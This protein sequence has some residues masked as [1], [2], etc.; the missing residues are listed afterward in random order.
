MQVNILTEVQAKLRELYG[1]G[2]YYT[3]TYSRPEHELSYCGK[4]PS[5]MEEH[6]PTLGRNANVLDIGPGYGTLL[7]FSKSLTGSKFAAGLDRLPLMSPEVRAYFSLDW[8]KGDAERGVI[9]AQCVIEGRDVAEQL[10]SFWDVVIMTEVLEHFNFHPL[11]TLKRIRLAVKKT[12][13]IYLSTP[14]SASW[15]RCNHYTSLDEIPEYNP[16]IHSYNTPMWEDGHVWQYNEAELLPLLT[17]AGFSVM[18]MDKSRS[19]GG[20]HFNIEACVAD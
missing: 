16:A 8:L 5:W 20:L 18:R 15:G 6:L 19:L 3:T 4:I 13:R 12:G 11:P 14:D 9:G 7:A 10:Y 17:A 2:H 1:P